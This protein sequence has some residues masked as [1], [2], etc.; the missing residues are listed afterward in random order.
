MKK[1]YI[2]AAVALVASAAC[3]KIENVENTTPDQ[4]IA[5]QVAN[6]V[7][8]TKAGEVKYDETATFTTDAWFHPTDGGSAQR[9]MNAETIKWQAATESWAADRAYFWPKTGDISFYSYA[10]SPSPTTVTDGSAVYTDK[11]I[12]ITDNAVLASA[13]RHYGAADYNTNTYSLQYGSNNKDVT[14]VPTLF[15]HILS[16][17]SVIVK[18]SAEGITDTNYKWDLVVNSA[19]IEYANVGTLTVNFADGTKGQYWP[20]PA[21]NTHPELNYNWVPKTGATNAKQA[22]P[23]GTNAV[24]FDGTANKQTVTATA[25][26][27]AISDGITILDEITVM[28]QDLATSA[29]KFR[30]NYTLTSYY[31]NTKHIEEVVNLYETGEGTDP[32]GAIA[33]TAFSNNAIAQW[34]MN[35]KYT[36]TVTI[37]PN[38]TVTFD[39]AVEAWATDSAGYTYPNN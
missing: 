20:F 10:G 35:Y 34:N 25:A 13:A 39:P 5:F 29:A 28:P 38:K 21:D 15:H 16:K 2:L 19:S 33:L 8:Q 4:A 26:G 23:A 6:Y 36:Y 22:A 9:F 18:F 30:I 37:K 24:A 14:G 1:F 27:D 32:Q 17:V 12:A 11:T 7:P 3:T 31:N